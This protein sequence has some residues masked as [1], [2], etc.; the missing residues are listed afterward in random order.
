M[1]YLRSGVQGWE[2]VEL[3]PGPRRDKRDEASAKVS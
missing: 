3:Q 2:P 1:Q